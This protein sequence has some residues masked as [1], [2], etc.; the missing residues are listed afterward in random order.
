MKS[1]PRSLMKILIIL[2]YSQALGL[3]LLNWTLLLKQGQ[4]QAQANWAVVMA[5]YRL[6]A[7]EN[8][9]ISLAGQWGWKHTDG[10]KDTTVEWEKGKE[11][12]PEFS[13]MRR[14]GSE[15][16]TWWKGKKIIKIL[17]M[18]CTA[19]FSAL[20][21]NFALSFSLLLPHTH[22]RMAYSN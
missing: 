15:K 5:Q 9:G 2:I 13:K 6:L 4:H 18:L 8:T 20:L 22:F 21:P 7:W 14:K 10:C 16:A 11:N 19:L 12:T 1:K 17:I 3:C